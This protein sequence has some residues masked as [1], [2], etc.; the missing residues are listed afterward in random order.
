MPSIFGEHQKSNNN[1]LVIKFF[2]TN[3]QKKEEIKQLF[4]AKEL[5]N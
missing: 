1:E 2:K 5:K 3:I 4:C